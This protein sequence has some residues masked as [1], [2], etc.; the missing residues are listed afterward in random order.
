VI[1]SRA[2]GSADGIDEDEFGALGRR[3]T[4]PEALINPSGPHAGTQDEG[5]GVV[6]HHLFGPPIVG[7]REYGVLLRSTGTGEHK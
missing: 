2:A 1:E 7:G 3:D 6:S 4:V 5:I